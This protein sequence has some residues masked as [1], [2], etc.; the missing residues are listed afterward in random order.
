MWTP[1]I[2]LLTGS[3]WIVD[4]FAQPPEVIFGSSPSSE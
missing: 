1:A 3:W 2:P 4:S